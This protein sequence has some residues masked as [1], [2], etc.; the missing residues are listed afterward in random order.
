MDER[1]ASKLRLIKLLYHKAGPVGRAGF[2][3]V[4][5][6]MMHLPEAL[7]QQFRQQLADYEQENTSCVM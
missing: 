4:I 2:F 3:A 1:L 7:T 5:D 6:W